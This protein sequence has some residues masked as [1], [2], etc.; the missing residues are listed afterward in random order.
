[1]NNQ[2]QNPRNKNKY[3]IDSRSHKIFIL[4]KLFNGTFR[5]M[6]IIRNI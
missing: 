3:K 5:L 6:K 2:R 4:E 1:M